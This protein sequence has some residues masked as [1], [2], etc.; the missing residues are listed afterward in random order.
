MSNNV[1]HIQQRLA[2]DLY[3]VYL[4][5]DFSCIQWEVATG[6]IDQWERK[7][8]REKFCSGFRYKFHNYEVFS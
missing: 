5:A 1:F 7:E 8:P 3:F 4:Y 6:E 2:H